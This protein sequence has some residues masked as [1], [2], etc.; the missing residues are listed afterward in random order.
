MSAS[1]VSYSSCHYDKDLEHFEGF[2]WA[3]GFG[4]SRHWQLVL[5]LGQW[6]Q[7]SWHGIK[8]LPILFIKVSNQ[9]IGECLFQMTQL[10]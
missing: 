10:V 9:Q 4:G 6:Q 8:I 5:S 1:C 2:T 3:H 7:P